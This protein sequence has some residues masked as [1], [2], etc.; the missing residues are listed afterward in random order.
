MKK[1]LIAAIAVLFISLSAYAANPMLIGGVFN[2]YNKE[3]ITVGD[4]VYTYGEELRVV[5]QF[6]RGDAFYEEY[7]SLRD[8]R[9]GAEV[10]VTA[11]GSY[12]VHILI[13]GD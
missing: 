8:I 6:R 12:A 3:T 2:G 9:R 1:S 13:K 4:R 10:V 7:S 11:Y 5:R